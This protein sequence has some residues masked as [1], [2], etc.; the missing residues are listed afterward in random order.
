MKWYESE[1]KDRDVVCSTRVRLARNLVDYPFEP[2]LDEPSAK[3][4]ISRLGSV[5]TENA[6]YSLVDFGSL[7]ANTR[8]SYAEQH[9]VSPEFAAKKTPHALFENDEKQIY[10]MACEEDHIRAQAIIAGYDLD[11]AYARV[12]EAEK[13]I[14]EKLNIAY[15]EELGYLT[16][17]P[18]N[19][20]TA[21][22]ASVM[23]FLPAMTANGEM[24]A[25]RNQLEKLGLTVRGMSGEGTRALGCLYQIS[26]SVTLGI[27][28][29]ETLS[30]LSDV[31]GYITE[32]ERE[33]RKAMKD[34]DAGVELEDKVRRS[35]GIMAYALKISSSELLGLY[36]DVR[37][38]AAMGLI[39]AELSS[40]D[41]M[42]M[43]TMPA[44]LVS[45]GGDELAASAVM[46][47]KARAAKVREILKIK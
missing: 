40:L 27:T 11:E 2:K 32:R 4:I 26:N 5:F 8:A 34:G 29:E 23:M 38:G 25:I 17:C 45:H 36:A 18:T 22:R 41:K 39:D 43:T 42:L 24:G 13:M 9:I 15:S 1:G 31:V 12:C 33:L 30:K 20:G 14:D 7:D 19:L 10:V 28:E 44:T 3:A 47:D 35:Y 46:R 37:L 21:M 6:G 16:H